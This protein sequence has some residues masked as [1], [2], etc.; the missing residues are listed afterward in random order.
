MGKNKTVPILVSLALCLSLPLIPGCTNTQTSTPAGTTPSASPA[1]TAATPGI[2]AA[3]PSQAELQKTLTGAVAGI[4][5]VSSY[6]FVMN[7][8]IKLDITG[9]SKAGTTDFSSIIGGDVNQTAHEIAMT[10]DISLKS[11]TN[12]ASP[13][14]QNVSLLM[15][16]KAGTLY[17]NTELPPLGKQ[18]LK[19]PVTEDLEQV[20]GL[21]TVALQLAPVDASKDIKFLRYEN[22]DGSECYVV[23]VTPDIQKI[24]SWLGD[25]LPATLNTAN[26]EQVSR[27][28]KTLSYTLWLA[29]DSGLVKKMNVTMR[30]EASADQFASDEKVDLQKLTMDVNLTMRMFD[31]NQPISITL[32][33]AAENALELPAQK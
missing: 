6:R 20:Y 17:L 23:N 19:M 22:F 28:F 14:S 3:P 29:R 15:Y 11:A 25:N 27:I 18:W 2:T 8:T 4:Q 9:G 24:L 30:L 13:T 26:M 1:T 7:M 5:K 10:M 33:A 32:P 16:V 21:N 31:Y 12:N